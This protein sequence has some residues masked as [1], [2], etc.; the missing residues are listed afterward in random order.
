MINIKKDSN[1]KIILLSITV[2]FLFTSTSYPFSISKD[3][4]RVPLE[5]DYSRMEE[6]MQD[7]EPQES[8]ASTKP[9]TGPFL[10]P[11]TNTRFNVTE[12]TD[13][14]KM[15]EIVDEWFRSKIKRH[16]EQ[17]ENVWEK[18]IENLK[19]YSQGSMIILKS[20]RGEILGISFHHK[21]TNFMLFQDRDAGTEH[22]G[23]FYFTDH[24]EIS[25]PLRKKGLGR[26]IVAKRAEIIFN[27]PNMKNKDLMLVTRPATEESDDYLDKIG[28][29]KYILSPEQFG[30]SAEEE[31][32][33]TWRILGKNILEERLK[34]AKKR[35]IPRQL[36]LF[37]SIEDMGEYRSD[38]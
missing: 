6:I 12:I 17:E 36:S 33:Y 31:F 27:D 7:G 5:N 25:G 37:E 10:I 20:E 21:E 23:D 16:F 35:Q 26:I 18:D 24:T 34:D 4:L 38:I 32:D 3:L 28:G 15:Q 19:K 22:I 14:E 9:L 11:G 1:L 13:R 29:E 8:Q 30:Y 2:L